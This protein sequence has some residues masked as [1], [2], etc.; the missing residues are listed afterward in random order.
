MEVHKNGYG[1]QSS[2][3]GEGEKEPID[4][5]VKLGYSIL[6]QAIRDLRKAD[7]ILALDALCFWLSDDSRDWLE[8][9]ELHDPKDDR[10][11]RKLVEGCTNGKR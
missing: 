5:L 7:H 10:Y 3:L 6:R 2:T 1:L 9:M 4:P 8:M 11:L